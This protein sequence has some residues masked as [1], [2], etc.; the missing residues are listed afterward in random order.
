M[1]QNGACTAMH[2]LFTIISELFVFSPCLYKYLCYI[3]ISSNDKTPNT[4]KNSTKTKTQVMKTAWSIFRASAGTFAEA[5]KSAWKF[6]KAAAGVTAAMTSG[7]VRVTFL[8]ANGETRTAEATRNMDLIP[9]E[10]Q[11]KGSGSN[12][13]ST[14]QPFFEIGKG[15]RSFSISRLISWEAL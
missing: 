11:P 14:A 1:V 15:W 5:L 9:A 2:R 8:K 13:V 12:K 6:V 10:L 3:C 7:I 4:M